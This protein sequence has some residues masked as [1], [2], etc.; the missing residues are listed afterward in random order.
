MLSTQREL[1]LL[2][3]P[4]FGPYG[5]GQGDTRGRDDGGSRPLSPGE[6][7]GQSLPANPQHLPCSD[8]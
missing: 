8:P 5:S 1:P 3:G 7:A 6:A 4:D 2:Q